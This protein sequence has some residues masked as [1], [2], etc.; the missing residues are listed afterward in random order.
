MIFVEFFKHQSYFLQIFFGKQP[1]CVVVSSTSVTRHTRVHTGNNET[2]PL[3]SQQSTCSAHNN[4]T[5]E[6]PQV[7]YNLHKKLWNFFHPICFNPK[8]DSIGIFSVLYHKYIWYILY[9]CKKKLVSKVLLWKTEAQ[10]LSS[11]TNLWIP[12]R[13]TH[14]KVLIH[15]NIWS[16]K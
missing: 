10:T 2:L 15:S 3:V 14:L 6:I 4:K 16:C 1:P 7:Y 13:N 5:P 12:K 9:F 8:M 11:K